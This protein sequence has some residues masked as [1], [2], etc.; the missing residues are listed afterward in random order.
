[1]ISEHTIIYLTMWAGWATAAAT[2]GLAIAAVFAWINSRS[3]L[4]AMEM[5]IDAQKS[6]SDTAIRASKELATESR[7]RALLAQYCAA[8]MEMVESSIKD[9]PNY[10]GHVTRVAATWTTWSMELFS[11]DPDFRL[12]AKEWSHKIRR[13]CSYIRMRAM[14]YRKEGRRDLHTLMDHG[15]LQDKVGAFIDKLILWQISPDCRPEIHE[16][17]STRLWDRHE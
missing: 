17:L 16:D 3:T 15:D 5:Q 1:M 9:D 12:L 8:L 10:H 2:I 7:Q 6:V 11:I 14:Y 4:K 13:E